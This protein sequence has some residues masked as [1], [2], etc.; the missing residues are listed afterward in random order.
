MSEPV[1]TEEHGLVYETIV[2][3]AFAKPEG[4]MIDAFLRVSRSPYAP[5]SAGTVFLEAAIGVSNLTP[6][7]AGDLAAAL[8]HAAADARKAKP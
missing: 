5:A 2:L 3:K 6:E 1:L 4:V 8:L 7:Q